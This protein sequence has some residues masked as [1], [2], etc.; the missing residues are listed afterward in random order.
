[1]WQTL[2]I[3][4]PLLIGVFFLCA[5]GLFV[6]NSATGGDESVIRRQ[7]IVMVVGLIV[8]CAVAQVNVHLIRRWAPPIYGAGV[9]LLILVLFIGAE[10]NGA[11]S[12]I[13][14][15]GLP[16]FQPSE[17]M[18]FVVPALLAW[19]LHSS[20]LAERMRPS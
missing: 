15:P 2:H 13:D 17:I 10:V 12:W 14:L 3:D 20:S 16:R 6:L 18:K 1:M 8:M 19:Y 11:K 4:P 9:A 5:F 7:G